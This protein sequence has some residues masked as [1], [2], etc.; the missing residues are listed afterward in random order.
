MC[1]TKNIDSELLPKKK[2][3]PACFFSWETKAINW[4]FINCCLMIFF[5]F[6]G[7]FLR[8]FVHCV[9][10]HKKTTLATIIMNWYYPIQI[11][12]EVD[13]SVQLCI[14]NFSIL[15]EN[16]TLTTVCMRIFDS[17]FFS[18]QNFNFWLFSKWD[19]L[20]KLFDFSYVFSLES[21][22]LIGKFSWET[23]QYQIVFS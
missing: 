18:E 21:T 20:Q 19:F 12:A 22:R 8:K 7:F 13:S 3:D 23:L 1:F 15:I 6:Q 11:N 16:L 5:E 9:V 10:L 2:S 14:L 4:V 17:Q